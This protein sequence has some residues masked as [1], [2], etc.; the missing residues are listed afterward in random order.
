MT[1]GPVR[2]TGVCSFVGPRPAPGRRLAGVGRLA[3][4][5]TQWLELQSIVKKIPA[6]PLKID[7]LTRRLALENITLQLILRAEET[8]ISRSAGSSLFVRREPVQRLHILRP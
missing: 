1:E 7:G 5:E 4:F 3:R 6:A 8:I 2:A